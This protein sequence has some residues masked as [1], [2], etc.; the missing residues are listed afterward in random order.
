MGD[1]AHL[2]DES[3]GV[4]AAGKTK[5]RFERNLLG[6]LEGSA[7]RAGHAARCRRADGAS[8]GAPCQDHFSYEQGSAVVDEEFPVGKRCFPHLQRAFL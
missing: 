4:P 6:M 1:A 8:S 3:D 5:M 7:A 2:V